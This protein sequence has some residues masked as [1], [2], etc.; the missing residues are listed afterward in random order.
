MSSALLA[1]VGLGL[2]AGYGHLSGGNSTDTFV[3]RLWRVLYGYFA[4]VLIYRLWH[5][6]KLPELKIPL[7]LLVALMIGEFAVP[8]HFLDGFRDAAFMIFFGSLI[9]G[10]ALTP[11]HRPISSPFSTFLG[12]MS[13]P[14]YLIHWPV[15]FI[16]IS[17]LPE[18]PS[19]LL[20]IVFIVF[21]LGI[22]LA[23]AW[24]SL[25]WIDRPTRRLLLSLPYLPGS[26]IGLLTDNSMVK[27][28]F[29]GVDHH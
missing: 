7:W 23:L 6:V 4:G 21:T 18:D 2:D 17:L 26:L 25:T 22:A 16:A 5:A 27:V 11:Q 10:A 28:S 3:L 24:V 29:N 15:L 19:T 9:V 8:G 20:S 14:L 1:I 12:E 13:Y